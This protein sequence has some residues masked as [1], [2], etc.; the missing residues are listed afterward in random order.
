[1]PLGRAELAR[2]ALVNYI[3]ERRDPDSSIARAVKGPKSKQK[4]AAATAA[5]LLCPDRESLDRYVAQRL[6]II[7]FQLIEAAVTLEAAPAWLRF[8]HDQGLITAERRAG[9]LRDIGALVRQAEPIW[10][11]HPSDP[12]LGPNIRA[13]WERAAEL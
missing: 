2:V 3:A 8:L 7:S 12:A 9:A 11:Q 13:A 6:N 10:A 1:M 4:A 5:D